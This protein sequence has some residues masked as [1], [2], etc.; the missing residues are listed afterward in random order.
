M[1]HRQLLFKIQEKNCIGNF[2]VKEKQANITRKGGVNMNGLA[3]F[4]EIGLVGLA[5]GLAIVDMLV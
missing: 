4:C 5:I 2:E 1:E 3:S